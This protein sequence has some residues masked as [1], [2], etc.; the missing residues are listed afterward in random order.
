M[1]IGI[2]GTIGAGKGTV[3]EYLVREKGFKHYS[4]REL[5]VE[6]IVRRGLPVNRDTMTSTAND[7]RRIHGPNY[8]EEELWRRASAAGGNAVIESIRAV[9]GAESL[10][11][12]GG[13][14]LAVDADPRIRYGRISSRGSE[15]DNVDFDTFIVHEKRELSSDD[16]TK[17][18]ILGVVALADYKIENNTSLAELEKQIDDVLSKIGA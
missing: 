2:T 13:I 11:A 10:K 12:H 3:V 4:A 18:N 14:L 6:E 1:I 9:A 5:I 7:L 8:V 15:T 16:P 17:Q